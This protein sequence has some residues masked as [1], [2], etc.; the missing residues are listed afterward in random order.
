M[1]LSLLFVFWI[2]LLSAVL[3]FWIRIWKPLQNMRRGIEYFLRG[4]FGQR[5]ILPNPKIEDLASALNQ[6]ASKMDEKMQLLMRQQNEQGAIL[7]SMREGVL[8]LDMEEKIILINTALFHIFGLAQQNAKGRTL[9][10]VIRNSDLHHFVEKTLSAEKWVEG[11]I[12]V[13]FQEEKY[14][15]AKG[16]VLRDVSGKKCGIVVVLTDVSRIRKLESM[17]SDFVSNVSHELKT[18]ITSIVG[19]IETLQNGAIENPE[20]A[21]RFLGIMDKQANRLTRIIENLLNL[22]RI[23]Q[24]QEH[25]A[26]EME[27]KK[28][29]PLVGTAIQ[30][31]LFKANR[32]NVSL[33]SQ[34]D[35]EVKAK[36]NPSLFEQ[37]L[38]NLIDNAIN[39]SET[40]KEVQVHVQISGKEI[41]IQV[42]DFGCGI[43]RE[44]WGRIFERFYRV[45]KARSRERGGTGLGLAI[46][47][48]IVQAHQGNIGIESVLGQGSLFTIRLPSNC[49]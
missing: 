9:Q 4:E 3:F 28:L 10:E 23:E 30:A 8:A 25:G 17:R 27:V 19:F 42:K 26:I 46:T 11:E 1:E 45:D 29:S 14:L 41:L 40:G 16:A 5:W 34:I 44:H 21:R 15:Q 38:I 24:E 48:H 2:V 18:P 31:C 6:M 39:A 47:K 12:V 32:K 7:S 49:Q 33:S 22:S 37:A 36:I 35:P 43:A 13:F 20:D